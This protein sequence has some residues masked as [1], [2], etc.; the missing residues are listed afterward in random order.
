MIP[1]QMLALRRYTTEA[2]QKFAFSL[3][4]VVMNVAAVVASFLINGIRKITPPA[5]LYFAGMHLSMYRTVLLTGVACTVVMLILTVQIREINTG[6]GFAVRQFAPRQGGPREILKEVLGQSKFWRFFAITFIFVGVKTNFS[7]MDATFP[8]YF[9]REFGDDASY[10]LLLAINPALIIVF[11]PL[12]TYLIDKIN[13]GFGP[14]LIIGSLISGASPFVLAASTSYEAAVIWLILLS[15]GESIWSPKLMEFG[16]AI[17]PEGR[18][19]TYM[20]LAGAPLFLSKLGTGGLSGLLLER[21][22]PASGP[23]DSQMMWFV[24]GLTT[25]VPSLIL[26]GVRHLLIEPSDW[27]REPVVVDKMDDGLVMGK[28]MGKHSSRG[29]DDLSPLRDAETTSCGSGGSDYYSSSKAV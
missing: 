4:Y 24:I 22:C 10:E 11:V 9:T 1:V 3:F 8:K 14:V 6:D 19:G 28:V 20:S 13:L 15:I 23:R 16:V 27:N 21:Y 7:H 17:A 5:G 12:A 29:V 2:S 18:E 25:F 26:I